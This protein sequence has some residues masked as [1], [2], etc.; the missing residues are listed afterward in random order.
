VGTPG[1]FVHSVLTPVGACNQAVL[2]TCLHLSHLTT[3]R[4]VGLY[5]WTLP[6]MKD[7][8]ESTMRI[9]KRKWCNVLHFRLIAQN[10]HSSSGTSARTSR[11]TSDWYVVA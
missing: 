1:P 4:D 10:T 8:A 5:A 7:H 9:M 2:L 6:M 3:L 11:S